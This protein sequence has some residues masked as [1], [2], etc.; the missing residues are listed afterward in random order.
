MDNR[1]TEN[2]QII[3]D[4]ARAENHSPRWKD[5]VL[6]LQK[7]HADLPDVA[8]LAARS[9]PVADNEMLAGRLANTSIREVSAI[10]KENLDDSSMELAVRRTHR[11]VLMQ[12]ASSQI[13][14]E[15][16]DVSTANN[17]MQLKEALTTENTPGKIAIAALDKQGIDSRRMMSK[18]DESELRAVSVGAY[19]RLNPE[20]RDKLTSALEISIKAPSEQVEASRP[21]PVMRSPRTQFTARPR[22]ASFGR[23]IAMQAIP[24]QQSMGM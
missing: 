14:G 15:R 16:K 9:L 19:D 22:Q 8:T 2:F 11:S 4:E 13:L 5:A 10:G 6:D 12:E 3:I 24:Q 18:M 17:F 1:L 23:K 21:L 7:I 20:S